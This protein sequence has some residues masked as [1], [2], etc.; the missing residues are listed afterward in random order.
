MKKS[1]F[2][3]FAFYF[4]FQAV[5]YFFMKKF[6]VFVTEVI[7]TPK[8]LSLNQYFSGA[9]SIYKMLSEV[10]LGPWER[11]FQGQIANVL[12]VIV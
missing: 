12:Y 1:L 4:Q 2:L 7:I 9:K 5:T 8:L 6:C 3:W 10:S 11:C